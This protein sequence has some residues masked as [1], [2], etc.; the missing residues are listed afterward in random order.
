ME[1]DMIEV[2]ASRCCGRRRKVGYRVYRRWEKKCI[3]LYLC[4]KRK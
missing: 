4:L 1:K 3:R 2:D